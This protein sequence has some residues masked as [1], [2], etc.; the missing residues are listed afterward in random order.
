MSVNSPHNGQK[1]TDKSPKNDGLSVK[2]VLLTDK[3]AKKGTLSVKFE[4]NLGESPKI[5]K[6]VPSRHEF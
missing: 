2:Y 3:S 6:S 4:R 1:F 5:K